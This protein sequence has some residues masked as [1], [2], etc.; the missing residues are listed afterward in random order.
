L[1]YEGFDKSMPISTPHQNRGLFV[2]YSYYIRRLF[3]Y[4]TNDLR[5]IYEYNT[6][7]HR[8]W[9]KDDKVLEGFNK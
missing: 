5:I 7:K 8:R 2:D 1:A 6:N 3:V 9:Y 4:C